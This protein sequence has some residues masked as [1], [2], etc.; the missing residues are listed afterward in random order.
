MKQSNKRTKVLGVLLFVIVLFLGVGFF[1]EKYI[2]SEKEYLQGKFASKGLFISQESAYELA[3]LIEGDSIVVSVFP[4][5]KK[6]VTLTNIELVEEIDKPHD[7]LV[8]GGANTF[9]SY[10]EKEQCT[11][12]LTD[13][14]H[15][16]MYAGKLR[17]RIYQ[18]YYINEYTF[19]VKSGNKSKTVVVKLQENLKGTFNTITYYCN[20]VYGEFD[21]L[22]SE[23]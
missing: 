11:I 7:S 8:Y 16:L 9:D 13:E 15:E 23:S 14:E 4:F 21:V 1:L 6:E 22:G 19:E 12:P 18:R 5:M 17:N 2:P 3:N 10:C 20:P